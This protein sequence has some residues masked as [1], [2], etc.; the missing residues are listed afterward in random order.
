MVRLVVDVIIVARCVVI[1]QVAE[2]EAWIACVV[3]A[4]IRISQPV[5]CSLRDP[6]ENRLDLK[7]EEALVET[8]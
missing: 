5:V 1:K 8:L 2:S 3:V 7:I 6:L 4:A